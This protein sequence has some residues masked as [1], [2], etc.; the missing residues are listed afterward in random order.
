MTPYLSLG[1]LPLH[2]LPLPL[3]VGEVLLR[4]AVGTLRRQREQLLTLVLQLLVQLLLRLQGR[5][6]L[7]QENTQNND[8]E[9]G[10]DA[11]A[12]Q[13]KLQL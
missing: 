1:D 6:Q 3:Q 5:T 7:L 13:T 9:R 11:F 10:S 2:R 8:T 4:V 12:K